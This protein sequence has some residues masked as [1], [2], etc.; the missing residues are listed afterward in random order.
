MQR[1]DVM[2]IGAGA[3]GL[4]AAHELKKRGT[5][6]VVLEARNRIGGRVFTVHDARSP[7]AIELGAEFLHGDAPELRDIAREA[8]LAVVDIDGERWRAA[9]GRL[10]CLDDFWKRLDRILGQADPHRTPDR[11][12]SALFA[13]LPGGRRFAADRRL[14][15]EFVEAFHAAELDRISER[16]VAEG[17]NP[18]EDPDEQRMARFVD[19][20][21]GVIRAL[22]AP[23]SSSI[24]LRHVVR[25]VEWQRG[26]ASVSATVG[27]QPVRFDATA[28][29]STL[30]VS[31]LH[32]DARGRGAVQF[33]PA[34]SAIRAAASLVAMGQIVRIALLLDRPLVELVAEKRKDELR[35]AMFFHGSSVD[36][37]VWWTAHPLETGLLIGW[38]GGPAAIALAGKSRELPRLALRSLADALGVNASRLARHVVRTYHHDWNGDPFSRGAYS[39]S[40]VGGADAAETLTRPVQGTLFFAGEATDSEGRTATVHGA[41]ASG[42]RAA[43]QALRALGN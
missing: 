12:I 30:P 26:S 34:V 8:K 11:A 5:R 15:R 27:T 23:V 22:A 25:R 6:V 19:G 39:Y 36:V 35:R 3:A 28:V 40:L 21:D 38:A 13:E 9:H 32:S 14:A 42:R 20:Y 41:I 43:A 31:L 16:S 37:P 10:T 7:S 17:G 1:V 33:A 24:R 4:A 18:G 29:I 2:V